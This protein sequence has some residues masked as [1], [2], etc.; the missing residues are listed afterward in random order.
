MI[1][2]VFIGSDAELVGRILR[3]HR[4]GRR[5]LDV[6]FGNGRFW[7]DEAIAGAGHEGCSVVGLD[8]RMATDLSGL[9]ISRSPQVTD[10]VAG[11]FGLLPFKAGSFDVV[12]CDPPFMVRGGEGSRMKQR[13]S[14]NES[15]EH[16]LLSLQT[17][18][19]EF[20]RVLD[21]DGIVLFKI[22][23]LTEG[24]RRRWAHIDI[25]NLW[26]R[27]LRLDDVIIKIAPH[28]MESPNWT[29]QTR[30][31]VAHSYFMVFKLRRQS[32]NGQSSD[33]AALPLHRSGRKIGRRAAIGTENGAGQMPLALGA[34]AEELDSRGILPK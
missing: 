32:R 8:L 7:R 30:S 4:G 12:V 17:A 29:T 23:D 21:K 24:R 33:A 6:T 1:H 34:G 19:P 10:R 14:S 11:D 9:D 26:A 13:Y 2:S 27:A 18:L 20:L 28:S 25:A 22:M 3:L 31:R 16:L 5:V 15:Y